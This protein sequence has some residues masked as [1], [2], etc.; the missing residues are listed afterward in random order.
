MSA[1]WKVRCRPIWT[2][3]GHSRPRF[4]VSRV[5]AWT[6]DAGDVRAIYD[7][8]EFVILEFA[9]KAASIAAQIDRQEESVT[10]RHVLARVR[11]TADVHPDWHGRDGVLMPRYVFG[12]GYPTWELLVHEPIG[13]DH[14]LPLKSLDEVEIL[15]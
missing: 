2:F 7:G 6:G 8:M 4:V 10:A 13:F 12:R 5:P 3:G 11:R 14:V 1:R 15:T 9:Y